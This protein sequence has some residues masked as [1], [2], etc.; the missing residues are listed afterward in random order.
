MPFQGSNPWKRIVA[1]A[2]PGAPDVDAMTLALGHVE[3]ALRL[4]EAGDW[5]Q[6]AKHDVLCRQAVE[7]LTADARECDPEALV[8]GLSHIRERYSRLLAMAERRRDQL[9]DELRR[10][11]RSREAALAY[12][13]NT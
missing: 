1:E 4:A 5:D 3:A 11:V 10:S 12:Q 6:A 9:A 13:D 7:I 8:T 2:A